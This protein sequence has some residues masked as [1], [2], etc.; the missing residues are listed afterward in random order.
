MS[1]P[2]VTDHA[3][4]R[5]LERVKSVDIEA[6]RAEIAAIVA[7]GVALG[8]QSVILG[9][10]RYRLEGEHVVTVIEKKIGPALPRMRPEEDQ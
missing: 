1:E 7:R 6:V 3:V 2:H 5:Y 8:A 10:M 9:G 4:I